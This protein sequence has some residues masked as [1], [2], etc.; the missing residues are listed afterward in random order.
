MERDGEQRASKAERGLGFNL[1]HFP[2]M[3]G[4]GVCMERWGESLS[5][6]HSLGPG[7][8][9]KGSPQGTDDGY[10]DL[11]LVQSYLY[12]WTLAEQEPL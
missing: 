6:A 8:K 10:R 7:R 5:F 2:K 1:R 11:D 9:H 3:S 12:T 4:T